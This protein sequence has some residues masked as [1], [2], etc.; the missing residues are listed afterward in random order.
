MKSEDEFVRGENAWNNK[1]KLTR[2]EA[3]KEFGLRW[4]EAQDFSLI[5]ERLV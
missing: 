1:R 5:H 3:I 2:R 4:V